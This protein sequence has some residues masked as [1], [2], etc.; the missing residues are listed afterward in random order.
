MKKLY[1]FCFDSRGGCIESVFAA[2]DDE[3]IKIKSKTI[4]LGE[5]LG[6]HSEISV[7]IED[8]E[9]EILSEDQGFIA[10]FEKIIGDTG[11]NPLK[12]LNNE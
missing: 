9:L 11:Y 1:R 2:T 8:D 12:Y 3:I 6:K 4:Y 7:D 5:V 10:Q